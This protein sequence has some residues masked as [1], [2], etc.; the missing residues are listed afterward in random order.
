MPVFVFLT[1]GIDISISFIAIFQSMRMMQ[2]Y[3]R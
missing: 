1:A 2:F 3:I